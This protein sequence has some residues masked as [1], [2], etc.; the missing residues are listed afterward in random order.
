[1]PLSQAVGR[2]V[3][4]LL[5]KGAEAMH[6]HR[7]FNEI[8]MLLF[9]H[10]V[11]EARE[12]R[13]ELPVNSVWFWGGSATDVSLQKNYQS[14]GADEVLPEMFAAV[15]G[16]PFTGWPRQWGSQ[17]GDGEQLLVWAGLRRALQCGDLAAWRDALQDFETGYARPLWQALRSGKIAQLRVDVLGGD[18]VRRVSLNRAD[19]WAFW[20]STKPLDGYI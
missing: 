1:V 19:T 8:Q 7:I 11:N 2:N 3:H 5:P 17:E 12:L 9:N 13:G 6:W 18:D 20:R 4:G 14:V 16:I 15:A 10:S